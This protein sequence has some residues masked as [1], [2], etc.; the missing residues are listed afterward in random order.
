MSGT[1]IRYGA[2]RALRHSP[3][4]RGGG[5]CRVYGISL[6]APYTMSGIDI[7]YA[8]ISLRAPTLCTPT[9]EF[10]PMP[11]RDPYAMPGTDLRYAAT[12]LR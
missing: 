9:S 12:R 8:G 10:L 4:T 11:L 1:D 6:R 5:D 7:A 3:D 2:T